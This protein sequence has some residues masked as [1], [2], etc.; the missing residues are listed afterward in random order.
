MYLQ[1]TKVRPPDPAVK[2]LCDPS[3]L[4]PTM[5]STKLA[6]LPSQIF[7]SRRNNFHR[8]NM[9][10]RQQD[11]DITTF[12]AQIIIVSIRVF[13]IGLFARFLCRHWRSLLVAWILGLVLGSLYDAFDPYSTHSEEYIVNR[14][15]GLTHAV[16]YRVEVSL[17]HFLPPSSMV[18]KREIE[19]ANTEQRH[20]LQRS[21]TTSILPPSAASSHYSSASSSLSSMLRGFLQQSSSA[22]FLNPFI[23]FHVYICLN[24]K[25]SA[26]IRDHLYF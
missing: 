24:P 20:G 15:A 13:T 9:A 18:Q 14:G 5:P 4:C 6:P 7:T 3:C 1:E 26:W 21:T 25:L 19:K 8:S 10:R 23:A 12:V 2:P 22:I 17:C 16:I 11:P